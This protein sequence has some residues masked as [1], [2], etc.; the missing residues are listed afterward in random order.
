[1]KR[2]VFHIIVAFTV[3]LAINKLTNTN[4]GAWFFALY[5][6]VGIA[7]LNRK[8]RLNGKLRENR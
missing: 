4:H 6:Y 8:E 2:V 3:S 7:L 1:M 5:P